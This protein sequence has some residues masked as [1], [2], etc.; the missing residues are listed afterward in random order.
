MACNP[1]NIPQDSSCIAQQLSLDCTTGDLS[2]FNGN[3]VSLACAISLLETQTQLVS[4]NL[5]GSFLVI[6]YLGEDGVQQT[7]SVDLSPLVQNQT[8]ISAINTSS[9]ALTLASNVLKADVKIDPASTIPI[10][11]SSSGIKFDKFAEIPI[12]TNNTNTIQLV[13]SGNIGHTLTANL[14]YQSSQS[15]AL[16]DGSN[17][18][19]ASVK[20]STDSG[21]AITSGGDGGLYVPTSDSQLAS[22]P[23]NGFITT[24]NSG[25]L[26]VG[27]DSKLYRVPDPISETPL[28]NTDSNTINITLSGP[29]NY[30]IQADIITA[31]SNSVQLTSTT[32]GLQADLKIDSTTPGN[33][34]LTESTNGLQA[35][36]N[37]NSILGVQNTIA[38]VQNP[39][40]KVYGSL[41]NGNAG[42]A[43][44]FI[45]Q[46]G[47]KIPVFTTSQRVSIP[48]ADLYDSML[49]FDS[50]LRQFMWYDLVGGGWIQ[51]GNSTGSTTTPTIQTIKI[52][53][54]VGSVGSPFSAG[55]TY[56]NNA[57]AGYPVLV[58]RNKLMEPD[59]DPGNGDSFFTKT[60]SSNIITF[61][62]ALTAG[63]LVQII[64]L[65]S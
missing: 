51:I 33:V 11:A 61:N 31:N 53:G 9:V 64:I 36:I 55:T 38:T 5:V 58:Y 37:G 30:N 7:K 21:N 32:S 39:I 3:T 40:T 27:S 54:V 50:T 49:V 23:T 14:K 62:T 1:Q 20:Y 52:N 43:V 28:T 10:S 34:V 24:G 17:G 35:S 25:T 46:Y 2:I 15:V 12:T 45:S 44:T 18:L 41:N 56:L 42:Y 60:L 47:I 8:G 13:G 26:I 65:P 19:L 4:L 48:N 29:N 59:T 16:S 6:A 63:E 57:M 22:L